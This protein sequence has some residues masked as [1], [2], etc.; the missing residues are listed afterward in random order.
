MPVL[1]RLLTASWGSGFSWKLR[2]F[3]SASSSTTPYPEVSSTRISA[4]VAAAL[5]LL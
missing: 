1:A 4:S 5:L 2:M 3:F